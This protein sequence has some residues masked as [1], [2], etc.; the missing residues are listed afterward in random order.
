LEDCNTLLCS[1]KFPWARETISSEFIENLGTRLQKR[2]ASPH[3]GYSDRVVKLTTRLHLVPRTGISGAMPLLPCKG[4]AAHANSHATYSCERSFGHVH[5][6]T[7]PAYV[8]IGNSRG[9]DSSVGIVGCRRGQ[10]I[11]VVSNPSRPALGPTQPRGSCPEK[12]G[13]L[14]RAA[15]LYLHCLAS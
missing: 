4:T 13:Q 6:D 9:L 1:S 11:T 10:K 7:P 3:Q 8:C 2:F 14:L 5:P 12:T 15:I